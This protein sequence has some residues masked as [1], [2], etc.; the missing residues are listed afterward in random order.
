MKGSGL[1]ALLGVGLLVVTVAHSK[2]T[3]PAKPAGTGVV[4]QPVIV[5]L[6][7]SE[8]CSSC[9]PADALLAKL[10]SQSALTGTEII[11]L[12]EHV[13]YWDHLGWKDPFSSAQW[14]ARQ[15]EY[16]SA[17]GSDGVYTPQMVVDGQSEFVGSRSSAARTEIAKAAD[18]NKAQ[19]ALR[20]GSPAGKKYPMN[21]SV[22]T[23]PDTQ[24]SEWIVW[25][26]VTESGLH[27]QVSRG[28][29][30]GEDLHHASVLRSL[31]KVGTIQAP[32]ESPF[33]TTTTLEVAP[34]WK[35][36]NLKFVVFV[37]NRKTLQVS[38]AAAIR[39]EP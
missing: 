14:T 8:G 27:S 22:Q 30:S 24:K 12:E 10:E 32:A 25:A 5:E 31:H 4:R 15:Q 37:Q 16:A 9:P 26:G 23:P 21:I 33:H 2:R 35:R 13:D 20:S 6:F 36:E 29:N 7:T 11:A 1:L 17:F 28:E 34:E 38:G 39:P 19:I 3:E 18:R